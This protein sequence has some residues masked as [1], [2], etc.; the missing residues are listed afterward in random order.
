MSRNWQLV[1]SFGGF[2]VST[3]LGWGKCLLVGECGVA[4]NPVVVLNS[5]LGGQTVVIPTHWVVDAVTAHPL[6]ARHN[7]GV[8]IAKDVADVK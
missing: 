6:V 3:N 1:S 8:G 2:V 7:I 4:S 5:A